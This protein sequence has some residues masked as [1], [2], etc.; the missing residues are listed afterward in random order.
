MFGIRI[1][2]CITIVKCCAVETVTLLA[3]SDRDK[4]RK[5][6]KEG[7]TRH[8]IRQKTVK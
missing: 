4:S 7:G 6:R 5:D 3:D 8:H 2:W 1:A